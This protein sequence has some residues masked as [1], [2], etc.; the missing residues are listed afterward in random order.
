MAQIRLHFLRE[1]ND[2]LAPARRN[3]EIIHNLARKASI[4]DVIESF[5][6]SH[7]EVDV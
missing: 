7:T 2:F 3:K 4:K 6:V 1:L 5:N